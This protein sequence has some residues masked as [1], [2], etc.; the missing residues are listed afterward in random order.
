MLRW[1]LGCVGSV[2]R[3]RSKLAISELSTYMVY[4]LC[5]MFEWREKCVAAP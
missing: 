3:L 5:P 2:D 4:A 1:T